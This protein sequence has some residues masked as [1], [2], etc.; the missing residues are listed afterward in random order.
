MQFIKHTLQIGIP[1][2]L[3]MGALF[4]LP[5]YWLT[6]NLFLGIGLGLYAGLVFGVGITCFA[7]YRRQGLRAKRPD[8]S[9]EELVHEG[10]ANHFLHWE[11]VGG[12]LYLTNR[13]L[14]FRSHPFSF[15]PHQTELPLPEISSAVPSLTAG[16]IP[17]G[18][19]V[20]TA[21]G[22]VERFI[23]F[24]RKKWIAAISTAKLHSA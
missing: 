3:F 5:S 10:P 11:G 16:I 12:W 17:N 2:G 23:V 21:S 24:G 14:L 15:Q 1:F 22:A 19:L 20:C 13:R 8:F 18:L 4:G 9:G 6:G 7:A